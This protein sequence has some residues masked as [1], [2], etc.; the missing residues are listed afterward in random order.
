MVYYK[1]YYRYL[2]PFIIIASLLGNLYL[3]VQLRSIK[4][5]VSSSN[6]MISRKVESGIRDTMY[7]VKAF[8][9]I[10]GKDE[11]TNLQR[12]VHQL[13][14][15][16]NNWM[17]INNT[18]SDPNEP[19]KRGLSGLESL[20]NTLVHHLNNNYSS[21]NEELTEYDQELLAKIYESLDRLLSIYHNIEGRLREI[22]RADK[23]DGGLTQWAN[24][25]EE[26]SRLYR[27]SRTPNHHPTYL[28]AD[29]V[30]AR[31]KEKFPELSNFS[32]TIN[33]SD[34]VQ[35]K[36]GVHYYE[37]KYVIEDQVQYSMWMDAIE[38]SLRRFE[39]H[40]EN[41][42]STTVFKEAA[43]NIAKSFMERFE[44]YENMRHGVSLIKEEGTEDT[45][46][47]FEFVPIIE[48]IAIISDNIKV[49]VASKNGKILKYS[50]DFSN[51]S[52]PILKEKSQLSDIEEKHAE[53]LADMVYTG[54]AIV[55]SFYT[56]YQ[57]VMTYSYKSAKN[58]ENRRLYFDMAT[59]NQVYEAFSVYEPVSYM[60]KEAN[61]E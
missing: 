15:I 2:A 61:Y 13:T 30:L 49:N 25:M 19:M 17:D 22:K 27:H 46:Y 42:S 5:S 11:L 21:H 57:P 51:T 4:K 38:G 26:I 55:R 7:S 9:D 41:E 14:T 39:D 36:D 10:G 32:G 40:R 47:A 18:T 45:V 34:K 24:N 23:S 20:R 35:M 37:I 33:I 29:T 3:A 8:M 12:S 54:M 16:F 31:V 44:S 56:N 60:D 58:E 52:V 53:K 48:D 50:S 1:K 28:E 43:L 59:G 6:A